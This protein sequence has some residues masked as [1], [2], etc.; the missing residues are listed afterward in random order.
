[1][2]IRVFAVATGIVVALSL[3]ASAADMAA[4]AMMSDPMAAE[5]Y[6]KAGMEA[7]AA[8]KD[9]K[10]AE[11]QEMYPDGMMDDAMMSDDTMM[12][13]DAM[14]EDDSMMMSDG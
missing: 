1:M 3:P 4:D 8:M 2:T 9:A 11:C 6:E 10:M 7:D 5:C 14:M 13:D 12:E